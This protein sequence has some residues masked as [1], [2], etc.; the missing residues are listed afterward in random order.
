M[1]LNDPLI[2]TSIPT[3]SNLP[4]I[5]VSQTECR[6]N[7]S[8]VLQNFQ[9]WN[10]KNAASNLSENRHIMLLYFQNKLLRSKF[11]SK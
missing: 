1:E 11:K 7:F 2:V 5:A 8:S 3:P 10:V 4:R 9:K 6:E